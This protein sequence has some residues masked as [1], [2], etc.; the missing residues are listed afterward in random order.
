[1]RQGFLL[2]TRSGFRRRSVPPFDPGQLQIQQSASAA[3]IRQYQATAV[4]LLTIRLR[5]IKYFCGL[6]AGTVGHTAGRAKSLCDRAG[7]PV[8]RFGY[9]ADTPSRAINSSN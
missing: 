7:H 6:S 9:S 3:S 5:K 4:P 2:L 1:M 8:R